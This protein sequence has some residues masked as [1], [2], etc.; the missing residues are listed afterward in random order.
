MLKIVTFLVLGYLLIVTGAYIFGAEPKLLL[1]STMI[2]LGFIGVMFGVAFLFD[3]FNPLNDTSTKK[4]R[5]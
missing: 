4:E 2:I 5:K 3:R 1:A